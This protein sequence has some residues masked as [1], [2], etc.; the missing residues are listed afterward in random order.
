MQR[1]GCS[2]VAEDAGSKMGFPINEAGV[3]EVWG[4]RAHSRRQGL[5]VRD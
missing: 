1:S 4:D 2:I 3:E 5:S